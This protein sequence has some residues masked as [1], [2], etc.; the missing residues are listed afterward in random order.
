M[1]RLIDIK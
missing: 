1:R